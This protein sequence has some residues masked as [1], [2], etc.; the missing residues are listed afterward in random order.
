MT[1]VR[2]LK[3]TEAGGAIYT[4]G[5]LYAAPEPLRSLL[6]SDGFAI[7]ERAPVP[8]ET[9]HPRELRSNWR[10]PRPMEPPVT[11]SANE[12]RERHEH[13]PPVTESVTARRRRLNGPERMETPEPTEA[14]SVRR[15]RLLARG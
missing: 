3:T 7:D 6:I 11:G 2:M 15:R 1:R 13:E 5:L 10:E 14:S 4:A 8:E 12:L 9:P